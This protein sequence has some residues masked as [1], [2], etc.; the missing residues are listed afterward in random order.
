LH[1]LDLKT[2]NTCINNVGDKSAAGQIV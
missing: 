2:K 1:T